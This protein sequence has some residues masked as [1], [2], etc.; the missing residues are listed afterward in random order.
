MKNI[1]LTVILTMAF[2]VA[3]AT[4]T[5]ER[6]VAEVIFE[7]ITSKKSISG[8]FYINQTDEKI[9]ISKIENF[10]ITLPKKGK[11]QFR[12]DTKD[13]IALISYPKRITNRKNTIKIQ[14]I[15]KYHSAYL[16]LEVTDEQIENRI[17]DENVN[18][19][20][21]SIDNSIP[22]EYSEFKKKYGI[23]LIKENCAVDPISMKNARENNQRI[24]KYLTDKYG[25]IWL[26][27]IKEKPFGIK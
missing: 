12:F 25:R 2:T 21:H 13:F 26:V 4:R 7:N 17:L 1:L 19:I 15:S 22:A 24:S 11:Y 20:V 3:N 9:A 5:N 14:L 27:G 23:G 18:F 8:E 10:K 16:G 6:V